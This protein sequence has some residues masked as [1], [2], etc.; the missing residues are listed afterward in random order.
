MD[1]RY[2]TVSIGDFYMK[3]VEAPASWSDNA[4]GIAARTYFTEG[5]TSVYQLVERV[6]NTIADKGLL[7]KVF[8]DSTD[9]ANFKSELSAILLNQEA[10]FNTPVWLNAGVPNRDQQFWACAILNVEDDMSSIK[11][12]WATEAKIFEG[13]SGSGVNVSKIRANGEK[14]NGGGV[15]SGPISLWMRPTDSIANVVKSG[16]KTR[17]AA[18]MIIMDADHPEIEEF[19]QVKVTAERMARVLQQNGFDISM[20]GADSANIPF[21]QANNSVRVT[22]AFMKAVENDLP[23]DL[24]YRVS[25]Q[26]AKTVSAR[27]LWLDISKAAWDCGDPGIQFH[28]TINRAHTCMNDGE[29]RASNPCSEYVFMDDTFCNLASINLLKFLNSDYSYD[30]DRLGQVVN[31]LITAMDILCDASSYPSEYYRQNALQYRTLGL[32]FTNLGALLMTLGI[33]YDSARGRD[34]AAAIMSLIQAKATLASQDL[35]DRLGSYPA[36]ERNAEHQIRVTQDQKRASLEKATYW[37]TIWKAAEKVW[38]EVDP[39]RPLRNAQ[40]TVQAPTGTISFLMDAET[41]GI[42]PVIAFSATKTLAGS[43]SVSLVVSDCITNAINLLRENG[44]TDEEVVEANKMVFQTALGNNAVSPEGHVLMMAAI[45]PFVSGAQSK[46]VNCPSDWTPE[47]IADIY[48]LAWKSGVKC[49]AIFRDGSKAYQPVEVS[50]SN[51]DTEKVAAEPISVAVQEVRG[52]RKKPQGIRP[53]VTH[54]FMLG[55]QDFYITINFYPDGEPCEVFIRGNK[56]G[57][58]IAGWMDIT[59]IMISLGL[60]Y[61]VPV[62]VILEKMA[63]TNFA[64]QGLVQAESDIHFADSPADYVGNFVRKLLAANAEGPVVQA[65]VPSFEVADALEK[66]LSDDKVSDPDLEKPCPVCGSYSLVRTGAHC[67]ACKR[68]GHTDGCS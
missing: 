28:D 58:A 18:K 26:V 45:Q 38:T 1:T 13:G 44:Q 52:S 60:Q 36:Y 10:A 48:M 29:Q 67:T 16:G 11:A 50:N 47:D 20:Q 33:P 2:Y 6:V 31:T 4:I 17:R 12:G 39:N 9:Y 15:S 59:S 56:H 3:D 63:G 61:G 22:D 25:G 65:S 64:P 27:K 54:K 8:A 35:A 21:Q 7:Y 41:T 14:I 51:T 19:I 66:I 57:S 34:V 37:S 43:G 30:S 55:G 40:L 46:T 24:T 49:I 5:E 42:E 32:G 68:C 23:W 53:G 62:E